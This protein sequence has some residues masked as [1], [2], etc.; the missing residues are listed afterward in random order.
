[1]VAGEALARDLM[2]GHGSGHD[3]PRGD[4]PAPL[5]DNDLGG[6]N[7]GVSDAGSWDDGGGGLGGGGGDDWS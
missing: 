6:Q 1:V 7:F 2:G 3:V 4:T 5:A